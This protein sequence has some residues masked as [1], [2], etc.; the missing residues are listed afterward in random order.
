VSSVAKVIVF[1][2]DPSE[3]MY[4]EQQNIFHGSEGES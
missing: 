1:Y 2:A 4:N 3:G